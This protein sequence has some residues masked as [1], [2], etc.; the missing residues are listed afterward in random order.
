MLFDLF[1]IKEQVIGASRDSHS[2]SSESATRRV[3][4]ATDVS[5][6]AFLEEGL[7]SKSLMLRVLTGLVGSHGR[8]ET[9]PLGDA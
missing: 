9:A 3:R 2:A 5:A 1:S 4:E 7:E 8:D 6:P